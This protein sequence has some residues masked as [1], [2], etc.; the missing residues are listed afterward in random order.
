M[1][2]FVIFIVLIIVIVVA[3]GYIFLNY[4]AKNN[5]VKRENIK[6]ESYY[7]KEIYGTDLS[8]I[9]NKM[10]DN[11]TINEI[12][13]DENNK[14]ID[15]NEISIKIDISFLDDNKIHPAEEI[16]DSGIEEFL[17]YY[18]EIKFKC[19]KIEYHQKTKKVSYMFFEQITQ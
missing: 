1:K 19:T 10:I 5:I 14:Y 13:K 11:N 15:N 6:L 17:K 2:K 9:M 12:S 3:T 7:D 18:R 4:K 8:T 16:F